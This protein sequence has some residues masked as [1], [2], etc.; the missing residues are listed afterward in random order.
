ME[1]STNKMVRGG[2]PKATPAKSSPWDYFTQKKPD[3]NQKANMSGKEYERQKRENG[4]KD[5]TLP[6]MKGW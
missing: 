5:A 1:Q 6:K 3:P 4:Q 2:D